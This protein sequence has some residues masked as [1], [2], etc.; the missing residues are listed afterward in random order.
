MGTVDGKLKMVGEGKHQVGV[1]C[2]VELVARDVHDAR[3][4]DNHVVRERGHG[5]VHLGADIAK[6]ALDNALVL[7]I[8][9]GA[10]KAKALAKQH[11]LAPSIVLRED[12]V[13]IYCLGYKHEKTP[14]RLHSDISTHRS[15]GRRLL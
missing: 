5:I 9:R 3:R 6:A 7:D 10:A 14:P 11:E 1:E 8:G 13:V 4:D 12:N 2:A 15:W